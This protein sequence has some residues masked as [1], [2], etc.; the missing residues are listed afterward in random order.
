MRLVSVK[1]PEGNALK[2]AEIAFSAGVDQ[3]TTRSLEL[4]SS[5]KTKTVRDVVDIETSTPKAKAFLDGLLEAPFFDPQT[6]SIVV[7][8]PR[9]LVGS[10]KLVEVTKPLAEPAIDIFEELW[11]FSHITYGFAG[12]IL[13]GAGLLAYGLVESKLLF[14]IAGLLFIPLLPLMLAVG[15]GV[16]TRQFRLAVQ[17]ALALIAAMVLLWLGGVIV[18]LVTYPPMRY[19]ESNSL[20]TG[21]VISLAVGTAAALA[22]ADDAGRREMIGLAATAQVAIIPVWFGVSVVFGFPQLESTPPGKR[23]LSLLVNVIALVLASM[24]TYAFTG[25]KAKVLR[26]LSDLAKG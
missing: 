12:R 4:L 11:Q 20:L 7:R 1:A 21:L 10:R 5:D 14:L 23:A 26:P 6:F 3:V 9:S 17:G 18:A 15:F 19:T 16:L 13:I 24:A 25:M 2:I 8:Q 22:T